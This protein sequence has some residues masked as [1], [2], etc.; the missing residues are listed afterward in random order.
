[1]RTMLTA[2]V[3]ALLSG[4][5]VH[6]REREHRP[7]PPPPPS[8]TVTVSYG[9]H[10]VRYSVW[11]E[12]YGCS[13]D[14]V[15][16]L[17][18]CGYDDDDLLVLCYIAR[19][20]RVPLRWVTYEYDRCGRNLFTVA[21]VYR[22]PWDVF[23]CREVPRGYGCP[24]AYARAYGYYWRGERV[25][26]ANE[27][28]H[29][30]VQLQIGLRYYGYSHAVYFDEYDRCR[31]RGER[32]F[33]TIVVRDYRRCGSGRSWDNQ[34]VVR[35]ERAWEARDVKEW[36]QKRE[37]ERQQVRVQVERAAPAERE[38]AVKASEERRQVH[39]EVTREIEVLK[40][41]R[42][43]EDRR[44]PV[45]DDKPA[46]GRRADPSP[47][48]RPVEASPGRP[49]DP[50]KR[51][52]DPPK[53]AEDPKRVPPPSDRRGPAEEKKPPPPPPPRQEDRKP[54][55]PPPKQEDR[56][57]PPKQDD[58]KGGGDEEKGKKK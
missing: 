43:D 46:T 23:Y 48:G 7:P 30:L 37:V 31:G 50:P 29:N 35:R 3:A 34:A 26:L 28:C 11:A 6:V 18:H 19:S 33:T 39:V 27:D 17:E 32:P 15:Y 20:A 8:T 45:P 36:E 25:F 40:V 38:K 9:W 52:A 16:Y 41:K 42:Q 10:H 4:C 5:V 54:P 57:P 44:N 12:Y 55:P 47:P 13:S 14:E 1:M 51:S 24:P 58:K 21:M 56:K 22:L 53:P 49:A 2:V